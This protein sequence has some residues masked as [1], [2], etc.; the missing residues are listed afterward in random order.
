MAGFSESSLTQKLTELNPTAPSIQGVS[1]W[2]LHH[3]KHYKAIVSVWYKQLG[4]TRKSQKLAMLYLCNDLVQNSKKKHPEIAKQFGTVMQAVFSH[5]AALQLDP[6]TRSSVDRLVNIW[7]DRQIFDKKVVA[8]I[9]K[10]WRVA[11]DDEAAQPPP[12][13]IPKTEVSEG[14][15]A[16]NGS[17]PLSAL[18]HKLVQSLEQLHGGQAVEAL[19]E[20]EEAALSDAL[21]NTTE[22]DAGAR[23]TTL[24][25]RLEQSSRAREEELAARLQLE[26]Y[27]A[28]LLA[29]LQEERSAAERRV[30]QSRERL[31]RIGRA[32]ADLASLQDIPRPPSPSSD[33]TPP[34]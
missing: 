13:K 5:L 27:V 11:Q 31:G 25:A 6:K 7:A 15:E 8:D 29:K 20:E 26:T 19:M 10:V 28:E 12:A 17:S 22:D 4:A 24:A 23:L 34:S 14:R 16:V 21:A 30:E 32:R 18:G 33:Q 2:L 9:G 3:R 1:L